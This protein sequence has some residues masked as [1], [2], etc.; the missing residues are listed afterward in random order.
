MRDQ[1]QPLLL[2][3]VAT[4]RRGVPG[5][6]TDFVFLPGGG[7]AAGG[8][9]GVIGRWNRDGKLVASLQEE[10]PVLDLALSASGALLAALRADGAVSIWNLANNRLRNKFKLERPA[11]DV[12]FHPDGSLL[13]RGDTGVPSV[14]DAATGKELRTLPIPSGEIEDWYAAPD[15]KLLVLKLGGQLARVDLRSGKTLPGKP[16]PASALALSADGATLAVGSSA[17]IALFDPATLA[18]KGELKMEGAAPASIAFSRD[19]K[20]LAASGQ[21][22]AAHLYGLP[23][24]SEVAHLPVA[25]GTSVGGLQFSDDSS[26]L[27]LEVE[28]STSTLGGVRFLH[29][30]NP[31]SLPEPDAALRQVLDDHGALLHGGEIE[32][33]PPPVTAVSDPAPAR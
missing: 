4:E 26:L 32:P 13:L 7:Y 2:R 33:R 14:R 31:D 17:R 25:G 28:G 30:G 18:P 23:G 3:A 10:G 29:I 16:L 27:F 19:G 1:Q 6:S 11:K 15:G 24:G 22:G 20:L 5:A 12:I 21:D 9:A 8:S